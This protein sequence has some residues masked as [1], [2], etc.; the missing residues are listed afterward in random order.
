[1]YNRLPPSRIDGLC[2]MCVRNKG[3]CFFTYKKV[4]NG[5][6]QDN[7]RNI[8]NKCKSEISKYDK[9]RYC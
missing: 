1:M 4:E 3:N 9:L 8:C 2:I 7:D 5:Y 6:I